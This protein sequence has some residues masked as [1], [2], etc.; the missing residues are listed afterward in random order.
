[1]HLIE[2]EKITSAVIAI[3]MFISTNI[4]SQSNQ[5]AVDTMPIDQMVFSFVENSPSYKGGAEEL[6]AF[7]NSQFIGNCEGKKT[8]FQVTVLKDSSITDVLFFN[9]ETECDDQIIE[10]LKKTNGNWIAGSQ[11]GHTVA[12]YALITIA[13]VGNNKVEVKLGEGKGIQ[14]PK[15]Q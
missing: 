3:M 1:M 4:F 11:R 15:K 5:K 2:K 8:Y 13:Y 14:P 7:L 6:T 12:C 9:K 10:L